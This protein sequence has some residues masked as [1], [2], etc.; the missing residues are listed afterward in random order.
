MKFGRTT[1][2][3]VAVLALLL[4]FGLLRTPLESRM[5]EKFVASGLITEVSTSQLSSAV[6]QSTVL[7]VLGGLRPLVAIYLT[8]HAFDAWSYREWDT[9]ERDYRLITTLLPEDID[10]WKTGAW[11]MAYNASASALYDDPDIPEAVGKKNSRDWILKG[12]EFL[13]RGIEQNPD[14]ST[15]HQELADIYRQKLE[16]PCLAARH[17]KLAM[18]G[19]RP[20]SFVPRFYGYFLARCPGR[21]REAYD[22]LMELYHQ[23]EKQR[24]PTLISRIKELEEKLDVPATHRIPDPDPDVEILKK[25]PHAK[26]ALP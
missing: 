6:G 24:L 16:E 1:R 7:A 19:D 11:H 17:Y 9:V 22:F 18:E 23:G 26:P 5:T 3:T 4:V 21:E 14:S 20:R 12:I 10:S 15:L 2:K 13:K 25:Y 8:L